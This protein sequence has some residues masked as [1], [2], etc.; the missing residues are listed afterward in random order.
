MAYITDQAAALGLTLPLYGCDGWDGVIKQ[1]NG[2][3][4]KI[5][6]ATFLTPFVSTDPDEKVKKFVETYKTL[7]NVE[8]DQFAAD[9]YDAV[10]A[11]KLAI[12]KAGDTSSEAL[13]PA[14]TQI[15]VDGLTGK[16]T[17]DENGEP[18]KSAKFA[19]IKDGAY[20]V[21]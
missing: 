20:T 16:M 15:T 7:Y 8:P 6:G 9:S 13:I 5:N 12:E 18:I 2:D 10:Y 14:M 21:E 17:F 1:L 11:I 3:T 19:V 4:S